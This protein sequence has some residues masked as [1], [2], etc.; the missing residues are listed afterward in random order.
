MVGTALTKRPT[1]DM[2]YPDDSYE[3]MDTS[4][5][6]NSRLGTLRTMEELIM[7]VT[8]H[9][10]NQQMQKLVSDYKKTGDEHYLE[11]AAYL[12]SEFETWWNKDTSEFV[13]PAQ[14]A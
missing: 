12:R 8:L 4:S 11:D 2:M 6:A 1:S 5:D 10:L 13:P 14:L 9:D 3:S 7:D